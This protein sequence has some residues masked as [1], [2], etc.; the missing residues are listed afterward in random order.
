VAEL[1]LKPGR[2]RSLRLRHPWLFS[3]AVEDVRGKP[4]PATRWDHSAGGEWLARAAYSPRSQILARVWT[5][6]ADEVIGTEF[7]AGRLDQAIEARRSLAHL[8]EADA[9]REVHAESDGLPGLI[10]DR[11]GD[12]R[13]VQVL[14]AGAE[15][16]RE[17]IPRPPREKAT[18]AQCRAVD[19]DVRELGDSSRGG[20]LL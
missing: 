4:A 14:S 8:R 1:V 17:A 20:E 19:V 9:Y 15:R 13:V 7:F 18:A 5:W 12:V 16:W 11:Y 6:D 2:D 10:L 3:G